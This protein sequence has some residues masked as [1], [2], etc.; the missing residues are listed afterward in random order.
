MAWILPALAFVVVV[1]L[2]FARDPDSDAPPPLSE[3]YGAEKLHWILLAL[4]AALLG[5]LGAVG[6]A[7]WEGV[8]S[9]L[10]GASLGAILAIVARVLEGIG[11]PASMRRA[12]PIGLAAVAIGL[13]M[14]KPDGPFLLGLG[15]GAGFGA[16]WLSAAKSSADW[17]HGF[18][19]ALLP[20]IAAVLLG[21]E[22]GGRFSQGAPVLLGGALV[23]GALGYGVAWAAKAKS[24]RVGGILAAAIFA[25]G[26]WL[27]GKKY[28]FLG[29]LG[30]IIAASVLCGLIVAWIV[31]D[32]DDQGDSFGFIVATILWVGLAT[33]AFAA[34]RGYG[35]ALSA[36]TGA[37]TLLLL[38]SRRGLLTLMPLVALSMYRVFREAHPDASRAFDI[39]QHY[40]ILGLLLGILLTLV[41]S[42]FLRGRDRQKSEVAVGAAL[43][44][45]TVLAVAVVAI[46]LLGA[47]GTVGLLIGAGIGPVLSGLRHDRHQGVLLGSL[48]VLSLVALAYG[49]LGP[50]LELERETK[51]RLLLWAGVMGLGLGVTSWAIS[52][53]RSEEVRS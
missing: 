18:A 33:L 28:L 36:V 53:R 34:Q 9:P 26:G 1:A 24:S 12:A 4:G 6:P 51:V 5:L 29:E 37:S 42:E 11:G 15:F 8:K 16:L 27:I 49:P 31:P 20:A 10:L 48:L 22:S 25:L 38:G 13:F 40:A 30:W 46:V 19:L 7:S 43:M 44:G 35:M 45:L 3:A 23:A 39:S 21:A 2:L 50:Y 47:K 14:V 17:A 52:G 32:E 41:P